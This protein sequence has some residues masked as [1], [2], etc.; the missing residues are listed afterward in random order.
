ML[1][2]IGMILFG[3]LLGSIPSGYW[4]VKALK[5]IDLRSVGSG[6]TGATNVLRAAGKFAAVCVLLFDVFKGYL[7]VWLAQVV[8]AQPQYAVP[9]SDW[10]ILP[11]IAAL[12]ALIGH[13][14]S[15]FLKFQGGKSAA[16]ALGTLLA[17]QIGGGLAVF[18]LW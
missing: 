1:A 12:A 11:T 9:L 3:Y 14:K 2:A 15:I 16:T 8:E 4:L 13:S 6:S 17:C 5:R 7:P 10:H 18:A